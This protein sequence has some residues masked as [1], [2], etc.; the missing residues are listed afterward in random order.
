MTIGGTRMA[1]INGNADQD[2]YDWIPSKPNISSSQ[3][4]SH[5][6]K[7]PVLKADLSPG[8]TSIAS[9]R[10]WGGPRQILG[11]RVNR[12]DNIVGCSAR[13]MRGET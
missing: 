3:A 2:D 9:F 11:L 4:A 13:C 1:G 12:K 7:L 10:R 8:R 5:G 6:G